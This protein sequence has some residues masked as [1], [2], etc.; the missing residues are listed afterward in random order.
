MTQAT[1][2]HKY[3]Q[4]QVTVIIKF[5]L[6]RLVQVLISL[7]GA[8]ISAV[9]LRRLIHEQLKDPVCHLHLSALGTFGFLPIDS[10]LP[11]LQA[12]SLSSSPF[13][14]G[15][16]PGY[17]SKMMF[18]PKNQMSARFPKAPVRDRQEMHGSA[19]RCSPLWQM[20]LGSL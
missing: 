6:M 18:R 1:R 14:T 8:H 15:I 4:I 12:C 11:C 9:T 5:K 17:G 13:L 2:V 3:V 7:C 19:A 16:F 10:M 20:Q